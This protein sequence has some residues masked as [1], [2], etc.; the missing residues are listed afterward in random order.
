MLGVLTVIKSWPKWGGGD[1]GATQDDRLNALR[2]FRP[3]TRTERTAQ[4][5]SAV[6]ALWSGDRRVADARL[7]CGKA[8]D[9]GR[10]PKKALAG[11]QLRRLRAWAQRRSEPAP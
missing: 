3:V 8:G 7:E 1:V 11:G 6:E 4:A 5:W 10:A 2:P 9:A